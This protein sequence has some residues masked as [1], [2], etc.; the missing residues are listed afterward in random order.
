MS[1]LFRG[2]AETTVKIRGFGW[3]R[4]EDEQ[5]AVPAFATWPPQKCGDFGRRDAAGRPEA[6]TGRHA[7]NYSRRIREYE[8]EGRKKRRRDEANE[9]GGSRSSGGGGARRR[10]GIRVFLPP[11]LL[12]HRRPASVTSRRPFL[13]PRFNR[14]SLFNSRTARQRLDDAPRLSIAPAVAR[15]RH[16]TGGGG[17]GLVDEG[18]DEAR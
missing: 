14:I 11:M 9:A 4:Q 17:G 18:R 2:A 3:A 13:R 1:S 16:A 15:A 6:G 5:E 8:T 10:D 7:A 12:L